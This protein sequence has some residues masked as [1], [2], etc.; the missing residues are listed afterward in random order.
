MSQANDS[1][2]DALRAATPNASEPKT[3]LAEDIRVESHTLEGN[4]K[5][6]KRRRQRLNGGLSAV[7]ERHAAHAAEQP[8]EVKRNGVT[9]A[10]TNSLYRPQRSF[11]DHLPWVEALAGED[12]ILL[13]DNRSVG[14]VFEVQ[15]RGTEGRSEAFL[16]SVRDNLEDALQDV[17]DEHDH[18]PWV[19]QTY[20]FNILELSNF[21]E[22]IRDYVH[23]RAQGTEYTEAY[24][25]L[26]EQHYKA[27]CKP[28]GLFFDEEVT[29]TQW[30]GTEQRTYAVVYRRY[31]TGYKPDE[32]DPDGTPLSRL[33]D[34]CE[35]LFNALGPAGVTHR[36]V[37][38]SEFHF[39]M[40]RWFNAYSDINPESP[41]DF[42]KLV[43]GDDDDLPFGDAF[44]ESMFYCCPRSD[45][46]HNAWWFDRTVSRCISVDGIRKRPSIGH[47]TGE[48]KNG[49]AINSMMDQLPEGTVMVSTVV[50]VP[51]DTVEIH[52]DAI[53]KAA[54]GDASDSARTKQDC[55]TAKEI[56]GKRHKMYR[57]SYAFYINATS[58]E[59][60]NRATN[61]ARSVLLRHGFRAIAPGDDVCALDN[62]LMNL[63]M[64][65]KPDLDRQ[66]N[67]RHAQLTWVQHIANI[68]PFLG[69][70]VGT[71]NPGVLQFNR[72][73]EPLVF[74]PLN[75]NDRRK[76]AHMM[77][78]G[79][80]GAGK[81]A[82]L[83]GILTHVMAIYRPRMFIIEAGNSHGLTA[84]WFK[85]LG[86]SVN[87]VSLKPGSGVTLSP[88]ADAQEILDTAAVHKDLD[89]DAFGIEIPE[90]EDDEVERDILGEKEIVATLMITGGEEKEV[91]LL[92]RA[93]RRIIRDA[94][95]L[96]AKNA[97]EEG[98]V[99]LTEHVRDAF[100]ELARTED[101]PAEALLR[102]REMGDALGLFCDGFAGEV[103][104]RP[105]TVLPE[106]DVTLIDL[107][108]FAR[109]GY[110][111]HLAISVISLLNTVNNIAER[112]QYQSR[113]IV[114]SIDEA[115]LI[116]TNP[117]LSPFLVMIVKMW[118]KLGAWL[119]LATQNLDDFP[120][121]AKKLLNM[122]EWWICLVMPPE[123][124]EQVKR[125]KQI[126]AE[127]EEMLL[128][129]SKAYRQ[130]TE[131]VV[132]AK[133]M[134]VLFRSVPPSLVL[135][136]AMTE[137]YEKA[138]RHKLMAD[139]NIS[140]VEAA[141]CVA[142]AV[143]KARGLE[144][145]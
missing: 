22:R 40:T 141:K 8:A 32:Y 34:V 85:S 80:T 86:V 50:F 96:A 18:G 142:A 78:F 111:A 5:A 41:V 36:R 42:S 14:A 124:V 108:H 7:L 10:L 126:N 70:A 71:G 98:V 1:I 64:A 123:E 88:F 133:N 128:S 45:H 139:G 119:W 20:T 69:R 44:S 2:K 109:V 92:R 35:K 16:S 29:K 140:E 93:H 83:A 144:V 118:R 89:E 54:I 121:N 75:K 43:A 137:K 12:A 56:M 68:S 87:I 23:E 103:F 101:R 125:F 62:Y 49:D 66:H 94:I 106:V 61:K 129:A 90:D 65:Y 73:G 30:S 132:L 4:G 79:P 110:E 134:D 11:V 52:I 82:T 58:T 81:S 122:I 47:A 127:Q 31:P 99:T 112:D 51:Q 135:A 102:I 53:S 72:G 107:A 38:G 115:H 97:R 13:E 6:P 26:L 104:N 9:R 39:W 55:H 136:L 114:V 84:E 59:D 25:E 15:P 76:N 57:A 46:E 63:P 116:T 74:D 77:L 27:V 120:D 145:T 95:I 21:V 143:D 130:Y 33:N 17:F 138:E 48:T 28:G 131:G 24:L 60:L 3:K 19:L 105:G 37:N 91:A 117:L 67:W 113:E 100:Y